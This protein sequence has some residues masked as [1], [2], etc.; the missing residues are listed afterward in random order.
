MVNDLLK[1]KLFLVILLW[2]R[3]KRLIN[4][5]I[6]TLRKLQE[7]STLTWPLLLRLLLLK[8]N[9]WSKMDKFHHSMY[10]FLEFMLIEFIFKIQQAFTQRK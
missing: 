8:L 7:T 3:P 10:M 9:N 6:Y 1:R 2:L 5:A 4:L